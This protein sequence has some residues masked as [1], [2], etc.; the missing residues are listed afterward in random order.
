MQPC[1][2]PWQG[3]IDENWRRRAFF[4]YWSAS[5]IALL[6]A[7]VSREATPEATPYRGPLWQTTFGSKDHIGDPFVAGAGN[8]GRNVS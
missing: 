7:A 2:W 4:L 5:D 6:R 8:P 3:C 1:L